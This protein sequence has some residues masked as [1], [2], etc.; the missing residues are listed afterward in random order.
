MSV[1]KGKIITDP[2]ENNE[3]SFVGHYSQYFDFNKNR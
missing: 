3:G 2:T 1:H